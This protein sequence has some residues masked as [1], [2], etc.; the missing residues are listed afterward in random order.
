MFDAI[1]T[2]KGHAFCVI[3]MNEKFVLVNNGYISGTFYSL[4]ASIDSF[5]KEKLV[6][7]GKYKEI[8]YSIP[9]KFKGGD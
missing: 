5:K 3:K 1:G 9:Y 2:Q 4:K 8:I 7:S 6:Q